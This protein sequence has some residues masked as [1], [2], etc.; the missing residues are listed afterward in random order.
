M[1]LR[2]W[3]PSTETSAAAGRINGKS[4]SSH[5]T[6][7]CPTSAV[8]S[9]CGNSPNCSVPHLR[10]AAFARLRWESIPSPL[11]RFFFC[12]CSSLC[13]VILPFSY[14]FAVFA[15]SAMQC[16]QSLTSSQSNRFTP[17]PYS[18][19]TVLSFHT[20]KKAS[21]KIVDPCRSALFGHAGLDHPRDKGR[22]SAAFV[23]VVVRGFGILGFGFLQYLENADTY[24][25]LPEAGI[26]ITT[27]TNSL[28]GQC[29][30]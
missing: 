25:D 1:S 18:F 21:E 5:T 27:Q 28:S 4:P 6:D 3:L 12:S 16:L 19:R 8:L 13:L 23:F 9:R 20:G 17:F 29:N 26:C 24:L 2:R 22:E 14:H 15:I 30:S 7:G 11:Q 10:R